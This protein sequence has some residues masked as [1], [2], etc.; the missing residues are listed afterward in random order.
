MVESAFVIMSEWLAST[1]IA[2]CIVGIACATSSG[3]GLF[4]LFWGRIHVDPASMVIAL[5][6]DIA[7]AAWL[8][9]MS[10]RIVARLRAPN[11]N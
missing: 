7:I 11:R 6:V 10:F 3:N 9:R 4:V 1:L 2:I 5:L 8:V